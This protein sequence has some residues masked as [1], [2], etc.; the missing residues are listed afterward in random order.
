MSANPMFQRLVEHYECTGKVLQKEDFE[1]E[2]HEQLKSISKLEVIKGLM[3]FD[4]Y[5]DRLNEQ[6]KEEVL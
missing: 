3:M 6:R 4:E 2:M 1:S 5:L